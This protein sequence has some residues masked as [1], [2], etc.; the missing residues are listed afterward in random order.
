MYGLGVQTKQTIAIR[1][2]VVPDDW[3]CVLSLV[4]ILTALLFEDCVPRNHGN[5]LVAFAA[6]VVSDFVVLVF[7]REGRRGIR[8]F[9]FAFPALF[10][11]YLDREIIR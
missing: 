1:G 6:I 9:Y 8:E 4:W 3:T 2:T 7:Y 5:G 10:S 11:V